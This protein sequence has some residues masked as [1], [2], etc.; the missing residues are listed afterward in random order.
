[1][2]PTNEAATCAISHDALRPVSSGD[3]RYSAAEL[4]VSGGSRQHLQAETGDAGLLPALNPSQQQGARHQCL[5]VR[6]SCKIRQDERTKTKNQSRLQ[7]F[8]GC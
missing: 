2:K 7:C 6:A 8:N 3:T 5:V 4:N 1:M